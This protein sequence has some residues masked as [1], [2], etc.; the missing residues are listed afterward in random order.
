MPNLPYKTLTIN[1]TIYEVSKAVV[2]FVNLTYV[3]LEDGNIKFSSDLPFDQALADFKA[4]K[5]LMVH[6]DYLSVFGDI[7]I[8]ESLD[9]TKL[10]GVGNSMS[11]LVGYQFYPYFNEQTQQYDYNTW[12]CARSYFSGTNVTVTPVLTSGTKI[13]TVDVDGV[14]TDLYAPAGGG[15][16]SVKELEIYCSQWN[17]GSDPGARDYQS[18]DYSSWAGL[19]AGIKAGDTVFAKILDYDSHQEQAYI[20]L[21]NVVTAWGTSKIYFTAYAG[22]GPTTYVY[23]LA[24]DHGSSWVMLQKA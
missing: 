5:S 3:G 14:E 9:G 7:Q 23:Y 18:S 15:G 12:I 21:D 1:G 20:R 17:S 16:G 11:E 10:E 22:N 13:A 8:T 2:T 6:T 24:E 19:I 4:G